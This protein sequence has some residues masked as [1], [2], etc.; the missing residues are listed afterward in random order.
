MLAK[1]K[2]NRINELA[3]KSKKEGLDK[4]EKE[5]QKKLREEYLK[6]VRKSFKNQFKSM[7]VVDP[8]GDD[9]TPDKVKAL[10]DTNKNKLH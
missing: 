3:R 4:Q 10:K 6:N 2:I 1:D 9:V 5:E 8:N 7:K